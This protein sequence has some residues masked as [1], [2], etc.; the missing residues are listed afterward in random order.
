MDIYKF[1]G[2]GGLTSLLTVP[3]VWN[4]A[5]S[6]ERENIESALGERRRKAYEREQNEKNGEGQNGSSNVEDPQESSEDQVQ[7]RDSES[8][9]QPRPNQSGQAVVN[10]EESA[11]EPRDSPTN[12]L[13]PTGLSRSGVFGGGESGQ[14]NTDSYPDTSMS[15]NANSDRESL[16]GESQNS[17]LEDEANT[18]QASPAPDGQQ[19]T[20]EKSIEELLTEDDTT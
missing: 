12:Y 5:K 17:P 16:A 6:Q 3:F 15:A 2:A 14:S 13:P 8:Q 11:A 7:L 20:R 10:E 4:E 1:I 9:T 18:N 19:E